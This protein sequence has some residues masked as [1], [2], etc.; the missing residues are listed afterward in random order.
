MASSIERF[1]YDARRST[2]VD[3]TRN[4]TLRDYL[5]GPRDPDQ[6]AF[7]YKDPRGV[8]HLF[9]AWHR[10][11]GSQ[12]E[13]GVDIRLRDVR[14]DLRRAFGHEPAPQELRSFLTYL[15][16]FIAFYLGQHNLAVGGDHQVYHVRF[17]E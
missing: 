16:D 17:S 13:D 3:K 7:E 15:A 2:A 6:A 4:A 12:R 8:L 10:N 14:M 11:P 9:G 1:S 5:F